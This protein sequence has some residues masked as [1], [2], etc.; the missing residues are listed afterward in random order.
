MKIA[1]CTV[2]M[3]DPDVST[4]SP[5]L[6]SG[7]NPPVAICALADWM[8]KCGYGPNPVDFYDIDNLVPTDEEI[9]SY[10]IDNPADIIG[11]SAVL[12]S[13]YKQVRRVSRL[14]K[15]ALPDAIIVQGG[16]LTASAEVLL[17]KTT[18]DIC[19]AGDGENSWISFLDHFKNG[20][21][22]TDTKELGRI[23]GLCF[24]DE[25][26]N[27]KF[28]GFG[29]GIPG[30]DMYMPD[31]ELLRSGLKHR[32]ELLDNYFAV[33]LK[34]RF[35]EIDPRC[36]E[37]GRKPRTAKLF[38]SK[39]CVAKCTFCQRYTKGYRR[40]PVD[41][42]KPHLLELIEKYDVGF[43]IVADENFGS[44]KE[45]AYEF[46]KLMTEVGLLWVSE[47]TRVSNYTRE[48]IKYYKEHNCISLA[49]GVES[50]SQRMLDLM[51]KKITPDQVFEVFRHCIEYELM[52][53]GAHMIF[54]MPG[55]TDQ[56]V[57]ETGVLIG[58]IA[59]MMGIHPRDFSVGLGYVKPIPGTP[60]Y[61]YGRNIGVLGRTLEDEEV[62]LEEM[63]SALQFGKLSFVNTNGESPKDVFFWDSLAMLEATR[64]YEGLQAA[65]PTIPSKVGEAFRH[66]PGLAPQKVRWWHAYRKKLETSSFVAKLPR[67][68][69]Y[70][71][72][73]NVFYLD[74]LLRT[75][76]K[77]F[78]GHKKHFCIVRTSTKLDVKEIPAATKYRP[79]LRKLVKLEQPAGEISVSDASR[80]LLRAGL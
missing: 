42:I 62:Y 46:A 22:L 56:T 31:Y 49:F 52:L 34:G 60:L 43:I 33:G 63:A 7:K 40:I 76:I 75:W 24:I 16:H 38:T 73:K 29:V 69:V 78:S 54:G 23:R 5:R 71:V 1:L 66:A 2:P 25:N 44:D 36:K 61:E 70:P 32:P 80:Q 57:T 17:R 6:E 72:L 12:S 18:V 15:E 58:R 10:F 77:T 59:H 65:S 8:K 26:D 64:V 48:D 14:I 35:M 45:Q 68:L 47:S 21:K 30:Q 4:P 79:S 37:P 13:S 55:E 53:N 67:A 9:S 19:I 3:E 11:I 41:I 27:F 39:G 20:G 74:F 51:E 28:N 50:G